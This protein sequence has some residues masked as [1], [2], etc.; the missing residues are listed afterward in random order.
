MKETINTVPFVKTKMA[1]FRTKDA[2]E[3]FHALTVMMDQINEE[4]IAVQTATKII[5][6]RTAVGDYAMLRLRLGVLFKRQSEI[7]ILSSMAAAD[8]RASRC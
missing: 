5:D 7:L 1:Y 3:E 6:H 2:A 4:I 8:M